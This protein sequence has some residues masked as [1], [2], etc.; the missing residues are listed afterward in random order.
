MDFRW[1]NSRVSPVP[2]GRGSGI[3][4]GDVRACMCGGAASGVC[5]AAR[6]GKRKRRQRTPKVER[7]KG[8]KG[9]GKGGRREKRGRE[10]KLER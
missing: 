10:K 1:C 8:K 4:V 2:V 5:A 7:G 9:K 3:L 6:N